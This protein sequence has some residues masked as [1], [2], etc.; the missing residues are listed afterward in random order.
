MVQAGYPFPD[1]D[2]KVIPMTAD[3]VMSEH[4]REAMFARFKK[5]IEESALERL[6]RRF[7]ES[8]LERLEK[9]LGVE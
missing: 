7:E 5:S 3:S 8:R 1:K 9:N 6:K 2:L 4:Y